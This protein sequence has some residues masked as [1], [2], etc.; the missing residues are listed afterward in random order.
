MV[1]ILF[2]IGVF[3]QENNANIWYFGEYAGVDFTHGIP[4]ALTD[5]QINTWEGCASVCNQNGELLFY[6]DG[7]KI[8]NRN[9]QVM[10]NGNYLLGDYSASQSSIIVPKPSN[11]PG[12]NIYYVF[13]VDDWSSH[14]Q[15]GLRYSVVD[16]SLNDGLG[17]VTSEKNIL[18]H[19][20]VAEKITAIHHTNNH[21]VWVLAHDWGS[22]DYLAYLVTE[23]GVT[24]TPIV[25][26]IGYNYTGDYNVGAGQLR[27]SRHGLYLVSTMNYLHRFELFK[28]NR[29]TGTLYDMLQFQ[30]NNEL[31]RAWGVE[32]S[33]NERFLYVS[34]RPPEILLQF[35]LQNW[36]STSVYNSK[37]VIETTSETANDYDA[38][39]LQMGPNG[40]I[41]LARYNETY[42]SVINKPDSAGTDCDFQ[43]IGIDLNGRLCK[44]GLPNLFYY[45][46]F[47]FFTGSE[48][49]TSICEGD[50]IFLEN[51]WQTTAG[52]YYDTINSYLGWDSIVNTHLEI[53]PTAPTPSITENNGILTSS[54]ETENQWYFNGNEIIGATSQQYQPFVDGDYQVAVSENGS[55]CLSFSEAYHFS[56]TNIN[57]YNNE[58]IKIYPNP[59]S[60]HLFIKNTGEY[61]LKLYDIKGGLLYQE[62]NLKNNHKIQ[63]NDLKKGMYILEIKTK[64]NFKF[65]YLINKP[66]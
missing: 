21:D 25:T 55:P 2:Y 42:L 13:T 46:G 43:E 20:K 58:S 9:H 18:L 34:R 50:S 36:D 40:K 51:N 35:D 8:Y 5:G 10:P 64:R 53:L 61:N 38:A 39:T 22:N 62:K 4:T 23:N 49:D 48:Q 47:M 26:S 19:D 12:N 44:W 45:K 41:Y 7:Q 52:T 15:D 32:F 27:F 54:S 57:E 16:M 29:T 37:T 31:M 3:S 14:F 6:T 65:R 24:T 66:L 59:F 30:S 1:T 60:D 63:L 11:N 28:F 56:L 33:P 17:D